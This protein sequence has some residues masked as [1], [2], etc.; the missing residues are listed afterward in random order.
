MSRRSNW[1]GLPLIHGQIGEDDGG[2]ADL[3]EFVGIVDRV[4]GLDHQIAVAERARAGKLRPADIADATLGDTIDNTYKLE[5]VGDSAIVL[6]YL[7]MNQR[8][9]LPIG[10]P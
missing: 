1:Q 6:T 3:L 4:A 10:T 7:P 8:Q 9:T 2:L 5:E